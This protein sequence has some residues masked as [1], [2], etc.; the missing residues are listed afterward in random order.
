MRSHELTYCTSSDYNF[1]ISCRADGGQL[2]S[3]IPLTAFLTLLPFCTAGSVPAAEFGRGQESIQPSAQPVA[4]NHHHA[5]N[6][7]AAA[8]TFHRE[9]AD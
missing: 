9:A 6:G 2:Y 7:N 3:L 1:I 8:E 5:G 4:A